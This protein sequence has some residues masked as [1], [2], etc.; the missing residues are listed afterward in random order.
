MHCTIEQDGHAH[1]IYPWYIASL[2]LS[3]YQFCTN[4]DPRITFDLFKARSTFF[5]SCCGRTGRML[6]CICRYAMTV[7]QVSELW[8]MDI[9]FL[10]LKPVD[11]K[12]QFH[13]AV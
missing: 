6:L 3:V 12:S 4:D 1:K 2:M 5:P 10:L 11:W 7:V 9:L 13:I 8:P